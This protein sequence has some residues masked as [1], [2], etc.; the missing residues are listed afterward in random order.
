M[1]FTHEPLSSSSSHWTDTFFDFD[2][3]LDLGRFFDLDRFKVMHLFLG[4]SHELELFQFDLFFGLGHILYLY[5]I[6]DLAFFLDLNLF[7]DLQFIIDLSLFLGLELIL[8][9]DLFLDLGF[10]LDLGLFLDLYGFK[11]LGLFLNLE[12]LLNVT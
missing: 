12:H 3:V 9:L 6:F 2:L 1:H 8:N 7:L 11:D 5:L 10:L 4:S